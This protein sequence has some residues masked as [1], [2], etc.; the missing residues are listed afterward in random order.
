MTD[1]FVR[2]DNKSGENY[3]L[4]YYWEGKKVS[5]VLRCMESRRSAGQVA[6]WWFGRHTRNQ[7]GN[8]AFLAV[9]LV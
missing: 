1:R 7:Y 9:R 2:K 8:K 5:T 3:S 6:A 4:Q